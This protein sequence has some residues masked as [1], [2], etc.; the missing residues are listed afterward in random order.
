MHHPNHKIIE[1]IFLVRFEEQEESVLLKINEFTENLQSIDLVFDKKQAPVSLSFKFEQDLKVSQSIE[2]G[3]HQLVF[4]NEAKTRYLVIADDFISMHCLTPY[5]GWDIF[6]NEFIIPCYKSYQENGFGSNF[7]SMQMTYINEFTL[8]RK[9]DLVADWLKYTMPANIIPGGRDWIQNH[10]TAL[11]IED[12]AE[13]NVT[14]HLLIKQKEDE[15]SILRIV[16][17]AAIKTTSRNK[18]FEEMAK[19]AHDYANRLFIESITEKTLNIISQ[20]KD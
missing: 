20:P 15:E 12:F 11:H 4:R 8:N 9:D 5:S 18:R 3:R 6:L 14:S 2:N 10:Q 16:P 7:T 13:L 19:E 17:T 1:A